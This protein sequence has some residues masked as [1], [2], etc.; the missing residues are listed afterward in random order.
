MRLSIK[1]PTREFEYTARDGAANIV[2]G[3]RSYD[4]LPITDDPGVS[5]PHVRLEFFIGRW[6]FSDQFSNAGTIHNGSKKSS[7]DLAAGDVLTLGGTTVT[8]AELGGKSEASSFS[9][10]ATSPE[11]AP[12]PTPQ[13]APEMP[14]ANTDWPVATEPP[15][16]P[17]AASAMPDYVINTITSSQLEE[18]LFSA[19]IRA[20]TREDDVDVNDADAVDEYRKLAARGVQGTTAAR[21]QFVYVPLLLSGEA[22]NFDIEDDI[23]GELEAEVGDLTNDETAIYKFLLGE[24]SRI[25]GRDLSDEALVR[26]RLADAASDADTELQSNNHCEVKVPWLSATSAGPVHLCIKVGK[27]ADRYTVEQT[28]PAPPMPPLPPAPPPMSLREIM[29]AKSARSAAPAPSANAVFVQRVVHRLAL[30]FVQQHG[31]DPRRDE[32]ALKRLN[33]AAHKAVAELE[34]SKSTQ[35]NLPFLMSDPRGPLHLDFEVQRRHLHERT[36]DEDVPHRTPPSSSQPA[37]SAKK[38]NAGGVVVAVVIILVAVGAGVFGAIT[39]GQDSDADQELQKTLQENSRKN[40]AREK[41]R[42]AIREV[43]LTDAQ[44]PPEQQMRALLAVQ[45]RAKAEDVGLDS[46]FTGAIASLN[47]RIYASLAKRYNAVVLDV[48]LA[49][50]KSNFADAEAKR[51]AFMKYVAADDLRSEPAKKLKIATWNE[52]RVEEITK[53]NATFLAEKLERVERVLDL[54]DYAQAAAL[55]GELV[56]GA[57]VESLSRVWLK[58]EKQAWEALAEQQKTGKIDAPLKRAPEPPKLPSF[59]RNDLLPLGGTTIARNLSALRQRVADMFKD[60]SITELVITWRGY[61]TRAVAEPRS[62]MVLLKIKRSFARLKAPTQFIEFETKAM[63]QNMPDD[64]QLALLWGAPN[65]TVA[66]WLGLMHF[67]FDRGLL[68]KAGEAALQVRWADPEHQRELDELLAAKWA[69]PIPTG[70]F[71]ERDG[72]IVPE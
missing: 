64:A 50:E 31:T 10:P 48:R 13:T 23:R 3:N 4:D 61:E 7:G 49:L 62:S 18:L 66:D 70:G 35:V 41:V 54:N 21:V 2:I 38:G 69:K 67:C 42:K 37:A 20:A 33:E 34:H 1:T 39:D 40:E 45:Q 58:T 9:T 57:I 8:V 72:R 65:K 36:D 25:A 47:S 63:I 30:E 28:L 71:P 44:I 11:P 59:P 27:F 68:D 14:Q 52:D 6:T 17:A 43:T 32:S 60:G 29:A 53:D 26:E 24:A 16:A 51:D 55:I 5:G 12:D 46:E 15:A 22:L 56:D 19:L